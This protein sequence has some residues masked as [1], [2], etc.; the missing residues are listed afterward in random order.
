M[1][2]F[3]QKKRILA[4]AFITALVLGSMFIYSLSP[5]ENKPNE[6]PSGETSAPIAEEV[7]PTFYDVPL[8]QYDTANKHVKSGEVFAD[9]FFP[10]GFNFSEVLNLTQ[11]CKPYLDVRRIVAGRPY[12]VFTEKNNPD[13]LSY[14]VY[15]K[16]PVDYVVFDFTD[17]TAKVFEKK[18]EVTTITRTASGIIE[19]SLYE[20]FQEAGLSTSI[21]VLLSDVFEYS[22]DF[23][24]LQKGDYFK[25]VVEEK[26]VDGVNIGQNK[27]LAAEFYHK[28]E[29]YAAFWYESEDEKSFGYYD[30][31][32][33]EMRRMFLMS[34]LRFGR[35]SSR[36]TKRRFHPVQKRYKAHLGTDYAAPR[37][38]PIR[39]TA[40]GVVVAATR[41]TYNGRYVKIK[42]NG[43]YT[44]QY[45]HM[46]GFAKGIRKGA[47]VS[48]G[49]TIGYVG[50]TGLATGPHVC[51]RFWKNGKQVDPLREKTPS[52][53]PLPNQYKED[54][55]AKS[56]ELKKLLD[57]IEV[58]DNVESLILDEPQQAGLG[59]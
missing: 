54:F 9:Y 33:E 37:G 46:N 13:K 7:V 26:L 38:T 42:H 47:R 56:K 14:F 27:I 36:Y 53:G 3:N 29:D 45:L 2:D 48:Q 12:T 34:P 31:K 11:A 23:Y 18:K 43:T 39:A 35:I 28:N 19:S 30:E 52:A 55:L 40:N 25:M 58:K 44:T 32:G 59:F 15:Q 17:T 57:S 21:S 20:A 10:F 8:D 50:S 5:K 24:H 41:S 22:I 1:T 6:T 4:G 49:Q 51:Y 16:N